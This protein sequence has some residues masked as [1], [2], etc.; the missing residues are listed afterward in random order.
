MRWKGA[1]GEALARDVRS[2][3]LNASRPNGLLNEIIQPEVITAIPLDHLKTFSPDGVHSIVNSCMVLERA[4][5]ALPERGRLFLDTI[6]RAV[7]SA[8]PQQAAE[9]FVPPFLDGRTGM[10]ISRDYPADIFV[11]GCL[12][13]LSHRL[14]H[15]Q[16]AAFRTSYLRQLDAVWGDGRQYDLLYLSEVVHT[17][18]ILGLR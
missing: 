11:Q 1:E 18:R 4:T 5:T 7:A 2:L 12:T 13:R 17:L 6:V 15:A 9:F 8:G 3:L 10:P 14:G 16:A